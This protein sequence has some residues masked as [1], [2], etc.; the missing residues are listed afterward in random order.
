MVTL[1]LL[2][3]CIVALAAVLWHPGA[4]YP[5]RR[6]EWHALWR[7]ACFIGIVRI[8][9][10]WLGAAA[11]RNPGWRQVVGYFLQ[12]LALPE[13]YLARSARANPL[14]WLVVG[15]TLL[16]ASSLVW[17]AL[18][19]WMGRRCQRCVNLGTPR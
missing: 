17:A 14:R 9:A 13:I 3:F 8:G 16:A 4:H 5:N 11:Y 7:L 12:M 10:L 6:Y 2:L 19:I 15:S 1:C 18:L